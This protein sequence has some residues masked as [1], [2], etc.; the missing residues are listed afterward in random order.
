[1]SLKD[2]SV[3]FTQETMRPVAGAEPM[4]DFDD[5]ER[6]AIHEVAPADQLRWLL[7]EVDDDL[8]FF[9]WL[10]TQVAPPPGV[11]QLRCDCVAGLRSAGG[12]QA[13]WACLIEAQGQPLAGMAV[14]MTIY[15]GLLHNVLRYNGQDRYQMMGVILNLSEGELSHTIDWSVPLKRRVADP[16]RRSARRGR[17]P[18]VR[19]PGVSCVFFIK[20]VRKESA[21]KT[22][23]RI[24]R[25]ELGLCILLWLP[26]MAGAD[27]VE[28]VRRGRDLAMR[29]TEPHLRAEYAA[30]ALVFAEMA[31]PEALWRTELEG[32][33]MQE[34]T[35]IRGWREE[36]AVTAARAAVTKVLQA[37]FPE[38]PLPQS[39]LTTVEKASDTRQLGDWLREAAVTGSV[40]DFER[41][42]AARG[43]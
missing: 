37:R 36:G 24:D 28:V 39:V 5:A 17:R 2:A 18:A 34:S 15:L 10:Q 9:T 35:V 30:L 27:R 38:T 40:V 14:W 13:P 26:L 22:L 43:T 31:G 7:E 4:A 3:Y 42:L 41:F 21:D 33:S 12:T 16:E 19:P 29:Q 11:P 25:G 1:M 8:E 6:H 32:F 23:D 20:N